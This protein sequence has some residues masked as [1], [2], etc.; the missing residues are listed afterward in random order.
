LCNFSHLFTVSLLSQFVSI[1]DK[2]KETEQFDATAMKYLS[3][4]LYP[5]VA[6]GAV[7]SLL[8]TPHK[9]QE[10]LTQQFLNG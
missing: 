10:I 3:Y 9:R 7:Y 4:A 5:L 1:S 6:C 8:Y 2:E